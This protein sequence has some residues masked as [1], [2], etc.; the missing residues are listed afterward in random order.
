MSTLTKPENFEAERN[1]IYKR[2]KASTNMTYSEFE[3]WSR[4][5]CSRKASLNR[6]PIKRNL[7]LLKTQKAQWTKNDVREAK[8][9]IAFNA[10]M[11]KVNPG[12]KVSEKCNLSKRDIALLNWAYDPRK[13]R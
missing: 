9:T 4:D 6:M 13:R 10:R 8:K 2:Y 11:K 12:R 3:K 1:R 7:R 5:E